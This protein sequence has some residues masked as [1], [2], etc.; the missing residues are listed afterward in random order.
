MMGISAVRIGAVVR[1]ELTELRRRR[2]IVATMAILPAIFL[3]T[4]TV[5]ILT[6]G[7]SSPSASVDQVVGF[8]IL[9]LLLVPVLIPSTIAAYSVVGE[10][11]QGTLEPVLTTPVRREEFLIGKAAAA[12]IPAIGVSYLVLGIFLAIVQAAASPAIA[13]AVWHSP[14]LLAEVFFIPLLA[15][16]AIW[17]GL[18]ISARVSEIRSAQ[19]LGMLASLP[20]FAL[21]LLMSLKVINSTLVLALAL[22]GVLLVIDCFACLLVSKLFDRERLV[23]GAKPTSVLAGPAR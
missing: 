4:P 3:I 1:K 11:E 5:T 20:P 2:S 13:A 19:Q 15:G 17:V 14:E 6:Q 21:T 23:T 22:G 8:T 18:A 9:Y 12:L 7:P 16:W 10:R